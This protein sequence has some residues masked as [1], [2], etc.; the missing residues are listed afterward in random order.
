[1]LQNQNNQMIFKNGNYFT[2][3]LTLA[4]KQALLRKVEE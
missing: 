3:S 2:Q 1:V 4:A